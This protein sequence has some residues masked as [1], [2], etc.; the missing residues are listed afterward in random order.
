M[1]I[2]YEELLKN[3]RN[4]YYFIPRSERDVCVCMGTTLYLNA[5]I[6]AKMDVMN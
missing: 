1:Y 2:K 3:P 5:R 4:Y 6:N